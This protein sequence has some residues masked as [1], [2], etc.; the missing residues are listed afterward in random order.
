M[1]NSAGKLLLTGICALPLAAQAFS[2]TAG[3]YYS[4]S[5]NAINQYTTDGKLVDSLAMAGPETRGIAFGGDGNL[6][7]TRNNVID[8]QG[9]G[10]AGVDVFNSQG[11]LVRQ[12]GFSGWIGG[13]ATSGS[14]AFDP[15]GQNFYVSAA[16]GVYRFGASD[17]VGTKLI[18]TE[19]TDLAMM[20]NG[21][22]L[23][24]SG[25][26]LSRYSSSG[27]LLSTVP[28]FLNDPH[29]LTKDINEFGQ[30]TL[31]DVRGIA[32]D[33]ASN[34]TYVTMLGYSGGLHTQMNFKILALDGFSP[35]L[36]GIQDY[37][38][39]A[40]MAVTADHK[41]LVGS[42]SQSPGI[43][44]TDTLAPVGQ[45]DGPSAIFVTVAPVPEPSSAL[46]LLGGLP[47]IPFVVARRRR[48]KGNLA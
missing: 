9:V 45:F 31:V 23:V 5:G 25:Y 34:R 17:K 16:D 13:L 11:N 43:F 27:S 30:P 20:P 46:L 12:Y 18:D 32:F 7:V 39:G 2:F 35:N 44:G 38:Y 1:R 37:W 29:G 33:E 14:I 42:S 4:S 40:D 15:S 21:D 3:D 19:T 36:E 48:A 47:A 24:A 28:Q 22:L 6:Y 8:T 10:N 41:L 26:S